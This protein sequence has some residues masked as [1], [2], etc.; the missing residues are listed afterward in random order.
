M[1]GNR[2]LQIQ[3]ALSNL[4]GPNVVFNANMDRATAEAY[5]IKNP[6]AGAFV[7][8]PSSDGRLALSYLNAALTPIHVAFNL[9]QNNGRNSFISDVY[10]NK[11]YDLEAM[12]NDCRGLQASAINKQESQILSRIAEG[13]QD[14]EANH[15]FNTPR[16]KDDFVL[17]PS[18]SKP[19]TFVVEYMREQGSNPLRLEISIDA[20]SSPHK[21]MANIDGRNPPPNSDP[22]ILKIANLATNA[23]PLVVSSSNSP[24]REQAP[25]PTKEIKYIPEKVILRDLDENNL[26]KDVAGSVD[27]Q[28]KHLINTPGEARDK[29]NNLGIGEIYRVG[30]SPITLKTGGRPTFGMMVKRVDDKNGQ[31]QFEI[32]RVYRG[33]KHKR[34]LGSGAFGTTKLTQR[35]AT[36]SAAVGEVEK[37][38]GHWFALKVVADTKEHVSDEMTALGVAG[39]GHQIGHISKKTAIHSV[40]K[41]QTKERA[42]ML[43]DLAS[44]VGL[45]SLTEGVLANDKGKNNVKVRPFVPLSPV[46]VMEISIGVI[47]DANATHQGGFVHRDIKPPNIVVTIA[48]SKPKLIDM[49]LAR[50]HIGGRIPK[51]N[52]GTRSYMSPEKRLLSKD[53]SRADCYAVGVTLA[54]LFGFIRPGVRDESFPFFTKDPK[55]GVTLYYGTEYSQVRCPDPYVRRELF[56][57][58]QEMTSADETKR[59]SL[60]HYQARI[61]NVLDGYANNPSNRKK[62]AVIDI[63]EH[64]NRIKESNGAAYLRV[65]K[66]DYDEVIIV[67]KKTGPI[68]EKEEV[69]NSRIKHDLIQQGINCKSEFYNNEN[70]EALLNE[71]SKNNPYARI[72][73]MSTVLTPEFEAAKEIQ[74]NRYLKEAK[75]HEKRAETEPNGIINAAKYY[76]AAYALTNTSPNEKAKEFFD[77]GI[78]LLKKPN[79]D[80]A[81]KDRAK[82]YLQAAI[83]LNSALKEQAQAEYKNLTANQK[84]PGQTSKAKEII[85][86]KLPPE[87]PPIV[88]ERL[89][90]Q[91]A[92]ATIKDYDRT[93]SRESAEK[94]LA[95]KGAKSYIIRPSSQIDTIALS[96]VDIDK[97]SGKKNIVHIAFVLENPQDDSL[98]PIFRIKLDKNNP[99]QNLSLT[100][101]DFLN[102]LKP[103]P[104]VT[105]V[106]NASPAARPNRVPPSIP[107]PQNRANP[108]L[109]STSAANLNKTNHLKNANIKAERK[110]LA[111][112][113]TITSSAK[114]PT[115]SRS[116]FRKIKEFI[117]P[118][119]SGPRR[120]P[121]K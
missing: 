82:N 80:N 10:D 84:I 68:T 60:D 3:L 104:S 35:V 20:S 61:K 74:S 116:I 100:L 11:V 44:G 46:K 83:M 40:T 17:R 36:Y 54:K 105:P 121:G 111:A 95:E 98:K 65:L 77:T 47:A 106:T 89:P 8:R 120:V 24:Q 90:F 38:D 96:Y 75:E 112:N 48:D 4:L 43:M 97:I 56:T 85:Y 115:K 19:N 92:V 42:N 32:Y 27:E 109:Q 45:D 107:V 39:K 76:K 93:A 88:Y 22:L 71:V 69:E 119:K 18:T 9:V 70:S 50:K 23:F 15:I 33:V 103:G 49:G 101:D 114:E 108:A 2:N 28:F 12:I 81:T 58:I 29:M 51:A 25:P 55:A 73:P 66:E 62:V 99:N 63:N 113:P 7:L 26:L 86:A 5:L 1:A 34:E 30:K 21:V 53:S 64:K 102:H 78:K 52:A 94:T 6:V 14:H 110:P 118:S 87:K 57:I 41:Q 31:K 37:S 117:K 67:A 16:M 79:R 72:M 13:L 91:A 59:Q